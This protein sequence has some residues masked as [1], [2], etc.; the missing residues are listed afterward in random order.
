MRFGSVITLTVAKSQPK[1]VKP[2]VPGT[3]GSSGGTGPAPQ[4]DPNYTGQCLKDG[5]GDYDCRGGSG[6]GPNYV[7]GTVKVVGTDVF[8]LDGDNDGYGCD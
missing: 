5:I 4:C 1:P 3:G 2:A 6:N 8:G 7:Y